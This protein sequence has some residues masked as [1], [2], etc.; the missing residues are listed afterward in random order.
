MKV[1]NEGIKKQNISII[2]N[3][4]YSEIIELLLFT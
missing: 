2:N 4:L 1:I 3:L